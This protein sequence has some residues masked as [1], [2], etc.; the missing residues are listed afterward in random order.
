MCIDVPDRELYPE[1]WDLSIEMFPIG[2]SRC[3]PSQAASTFSNGEGDVDAFRTRDA[4]IRARRMAAKYAAGVR[5]ER[6]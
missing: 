6:S 5:I 4:R 1:S 2:Y 3:V